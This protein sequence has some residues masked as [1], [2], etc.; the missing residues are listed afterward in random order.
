MIR[1]YYSGDYE[2][3]VQ[4]IVDN[5]LKMPSPQELGGYGLVWEEDDKIVGFIW[6]LTSDDSA[7]VFVD[8]FVVDPNYRDEE[9]N[10]GRGFIAVSLMMAFL[11]DMQKKG[12]TRVMGQLPEGKL[13][14][15]LARIYN[16][17]GMNFYTPYLFVDGY[18]PMIVKN[19]KEG[20]HGK[21][22]STK[23]RDT[24]SNA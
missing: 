20:K 16:N 18:I 4:L 13:S 17:V 11:T 2:Q 22:H 8:Y 5:G 12:K 6:A 10:V 1:P 9:D 3:V 24:R 14:E 15:S 19:M 23:D 7:S 21:H